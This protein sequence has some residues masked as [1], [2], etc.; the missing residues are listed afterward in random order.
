[1]SKST[2]TYRFLHGPRVRAWGYVNLEAWALPLY[3][4]KFKGFLNIHLGPFS[5]SFDWG[6]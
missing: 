6:A 4:R 5:V 1:M 2:K 3:V